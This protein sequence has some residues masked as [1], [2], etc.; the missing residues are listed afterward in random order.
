MVVAQIN[1]NFHMCCYRVLLGI[2]LLMVEGTNVGL[3][4]GTLT[5]VKS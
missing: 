1:I 4:V 3:K 5:Q 2:G